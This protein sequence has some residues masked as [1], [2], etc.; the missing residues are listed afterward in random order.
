MGAHCLCGVST[1]SPSGIYLE[2]V[3][4][5]FWFSLFR[6]PQY[7]FPQWLHK[8]YSAIRNDWVS[9]PPPT[10][11]SSPAL[12]VLCFLA[13]FNWTQFFHATVWSRL[14][15]PQLQDFSP[16]HPHNP[17]FLLFKNAN[18]K[19]ITKNKHM[20]PCKNIQA[21]IPIRFFL[22]A[23]TKQCE[24]EHL[25]KH[26]WVHLALINYSCSL[27]WSVVNTPGQTPWEKTWHCF[28][29]SLANSGFYNRSASSST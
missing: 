25:Q 1:Y 3:L 26:H 21:K 27:P 4:C 16:P 6:R 8:A 18:K 2:V 13:F 23:Q 29:E 24:T 14:P 9:P 7:W 28:L 20:R 5:Q 19:Q 10:P 22:N 11:I 15:F 17:T 12:V